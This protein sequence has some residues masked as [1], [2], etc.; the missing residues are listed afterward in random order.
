MFWDVRASAKCGEVK[1]L[2]NEGLFSVACTGT[3]VVAGGTRG[4]IY[5]WDIRGFKLI[6]TLEDCHTDNVTQVLSILS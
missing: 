2:N 5:I 3:T 6:R 4:A 1:S